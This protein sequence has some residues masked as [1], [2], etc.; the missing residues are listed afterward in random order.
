MSRVSVTGAGAAERQLVGV[1]LLLVAKSYKVVG[2]YLTCT[3]EV[4]PKSVQLN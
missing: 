1:G 3:G 2:K 4:V